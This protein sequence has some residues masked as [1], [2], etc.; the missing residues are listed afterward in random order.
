[1]DLDQEHHTVSWLDCDTIADGGKRIVKC[2]KCSVCSKFKVSI[3]GRC[4]FS[5]QWIVGADSVLILKMFSQLSKIT[6]DVSE[7]SLCRAV[8][9]S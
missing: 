9:H 1:M 3:I 6:S 4:N 2:L 7:I 8:Y 5:E